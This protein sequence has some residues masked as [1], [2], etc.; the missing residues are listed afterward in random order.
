M[1]GWMF[2]SLSF[3]LIFFPEDS[4]RLQESVSQGDRVRMAVS[5]HLSKVFLVGYEFISTI[6]VSNTKSWPNC[7]SPLSCNKV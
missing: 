6:V 7:F 5:K 1:K 2:S 4:E 3:C